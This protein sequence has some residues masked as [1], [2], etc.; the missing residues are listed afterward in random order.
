MPGDLTPLEIVGGLVP[1]VVA[2]MTLAAFHWRRRDEVFTEVTPGEV[3]RLGSGTGSSRVRRGVEWA[4]S[5]APRFHAPDESTPALSGTVLDGIVHGRDLTATLVDLALRGIVSLEK[6]GDD[7][8]VSRTGVGDDTMADHEQVLLNSLLGQADSVRL[9]ELRRADVAQRWREAEIAVYRAVVDRGWYSK[10]PRSRN[11]WLSA[12]GVILV[13]GAVVAGVASGIADDHW[14]WVP[15]GVGLGLGGALLVRLGR[16]RTPR[17]AAGSAARIQALG[18]EKYLATAEANQLRRE[19]LAGEV[20]SMLPYAVAFGVAPH[21]ASVLADALRAAKLAE[22]AQNALAVAVDA[23]L[24]PGVLHL[25]SG[26]VD[27]GG[28]LDVPDLGAL[29]DLVPDDA[30]S[31]LV[32]GFEGLGSALSSFAGGIGD[33]VPD[34]DFLD[35]CDSGCLDF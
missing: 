24:D 35:G 32:E 10:H 33:L 22:G 16:G 1:L 8:R 12:L 11:G 26:L 15:L 5:V 27:L 18:Y 19:E 17:T 34:G 25:V 4:G 31:A 9:G 13:L 14:R 29:G 21:V 3:P 2:V 20:R 6:E 23:S 30:V 28:A 7:F